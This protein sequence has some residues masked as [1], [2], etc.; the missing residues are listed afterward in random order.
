MEGVDSQTYITNDNRQARFQAENAGAF[1]TLT[2]T[3]LYCLSTNR[4]PQ[5]S[6]KQRLAS[7]TV[8]YGYNVPPGLQPLN[9]T[10][11]LKLNRSLEH[12]S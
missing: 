6:R 10:G 11:G 2:N 8:T 3:I 4:T 7:F 9:P 5:S 1:S 12:L